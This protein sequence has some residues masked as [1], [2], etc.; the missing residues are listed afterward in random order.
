MYKLYEGRELKTN[1]AATQ[2]FHGLLLQ[3]S[4]HALLPLYTLGTDQFLEQ[5]VD[6]ETKTSRV[7][8]CRV[9]NRFNETLRAPEH[10]TDRESFSLSILN[11]RA[12][13]LFSSCVNRCILTLGATLWDPPSIRAR[14]LCGAV[15][16]QLI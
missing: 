4:V 9:C 13:P 11:I 16:L 1:I 8:A 2:D 15:A 5:L 12:F 14:S 6:S 7:I 3:A 10:E